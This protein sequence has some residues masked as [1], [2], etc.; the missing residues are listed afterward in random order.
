MYGRKLIPTR[1][2]LKKD[3]T[4]GLRWA[5]NPCFSFFS[6]RIYMA[7][8]ERTLVRLRQFTKLLICKHLSG[9]TSPLFYIYKLQRR[10]VKRSVALEAIMEAMAVQL[11][12]ALDPEESGE[13][14]VRQALAFE[15]QLPEDL[16]VFDTSKVVA[17]L[18]VDALEK[19]GLIF[20]EG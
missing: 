2:S 7:C 17:E 18:A 14:F 19:V 20:E 13:E 12:V 9:S 1:W 10:I 4:T 3:L 16:T 15:K 6:R 5:S 8:N 11:V